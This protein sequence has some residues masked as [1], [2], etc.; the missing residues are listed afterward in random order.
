MN[1]RSSSAL[2]TI[3]QKTS[4]AQR[5]VIV[6]TGVA[7]VFLLIVAACG[8]PSSTEAK[9]IAPTT[10]TTAGTT[11]TTTTTSATATVPPTAT[12]TALDDAI[13]IVLD[14]GLRVGLDG[15]AE[16]GECWRASALDF[17]TVTLLHQQVRLTTTG[18]SPW[19]VIVTLADGTD[20]AAL[21]VSKGVA[22]VVAGATPGTLL[23][24]QDS[25]K[26][27]T[28][29]LWG[30]P[31]RGSDTPLPPAVAP[32]PPPRKAAPAPKPPT[33]P[34]PPAPAPAYYA[35]CSAARAAGVAPLY[36]GQ[37]GYRSALDR[38]NDG[39]ACE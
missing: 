12:V 1:A 6:S 13:T 7:A 39:V 36:R 8:T 22:R 23:S 3:W 32:P 37:P 9:P 24:K 25:A 27:A 26:R 18:S 34:K 19:R 28:V 5:I 15:L 10:K 4:T 30:A 16:P 14:N 38:D 21:A 2:T 11:T 29:G 35:N 31:C 20:F 33:P 17:A